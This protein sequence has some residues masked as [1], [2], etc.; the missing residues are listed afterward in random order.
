M[1]PLYSAYLFFPGGVIAADYPANVVSRGSNVLS[2]IFADSSA[3][4]GIANPYTTD[5]NGFITFYA[6]PGDY[7]A[8]FGSE[9]VP[10][11][12]DLSVTDDVWADLFVHTQASPSA[13]WTVA[14]HFGVEPTVE[15]LVGGVHVDADVSHTDTEHTV[16]TFGS[17]IAGTAYLRR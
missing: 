2:L 7:L 6:A 4:T 1:L 17:S 3:V 13:T 8:V 9:S 10:V 5:S 16:I 11:P 14:H 15:V 12:L